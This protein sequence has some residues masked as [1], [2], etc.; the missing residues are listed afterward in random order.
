MRRSDFHW[1]RYIQPIEYCLRYMLFILVL[2]FHYMCLSK[3][4]TLG[5][6]EVQLFSWCIS[7]IRLCVVLILSCILRPLWFIRNFHRKF[8]GL[9]SLGI[10]PEWA[11][12]FKG[13][14]PI[15]MFSQVPWIAYEIFHSLKPIG[16]IQWFSF[17]MVQ[18]KKHAHVYISTVAVR[19]NRSKRNYCTCTNL[20][21]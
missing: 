19:C 18:S 17:H 1:I 7:P 5:S 20:K 15:G 14:N 6:R 8:G 12:W 11:V 2:F 21:F 13:L 9:E 10:F 3:F 16:K 4:L